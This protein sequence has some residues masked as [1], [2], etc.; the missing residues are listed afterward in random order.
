MKREIKFRGKS[1]DTGKWVYGFL[2][3]S[4]LPEGT[5]TDLS[6]R[7]RRGYIPR[8]TAG[9]MTYGLKPSGSSPDCVIKRERDLRGGYCKN[10]RIWY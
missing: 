1:T 10:Q 7:T 2:S 4:I 3:F 8:K 9:A 5:K 6:S